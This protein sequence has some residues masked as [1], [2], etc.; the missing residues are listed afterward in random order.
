MNILIISEQNI[1]FVQK[2]LNVFKKGSEQFFKNSTFY[3][4]LLTFQQYAPTHYAAKFN[5]RNKFIRTA[6]VNI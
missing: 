3:S 6:G 5:L 2:I 4:Y 1:T